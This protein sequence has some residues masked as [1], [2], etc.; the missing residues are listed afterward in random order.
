MTEPTEA[1]RAGEPHDAPA[2]DTPTA[3]APQSAPRPDPF[4]K[5][6]GSGIAKGRKEGARE[7]LESLG[8]GTLEEAVAAREHLDEARTAEERKI[9]QTEAEARKIRQ[10]LEGARKELERLR[11]YAD[12]ARLD[13][14]RALALAAGVGQG[15]QLEA[16]VALH[17][18]NVRWADDRTLAVVARRNGVD[19]EPT[20]EALEDWVARAVA[21]SPFLQAPR[22]ARGAG[23]AVEPTAGPGVKSEMHRILGLKG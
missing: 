18:D 22:G 15:R 11:G 16:F 9:S 2:S 19:P 23:S 6:Y 7:V 5:G 12:E 10:E 21:D 14:V 17:G 1:P 13:K 8:Y 3:S 20:G 4:A